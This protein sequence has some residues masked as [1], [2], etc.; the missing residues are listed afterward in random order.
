MIYPLFCH[1][2]IHA[3]DRLKKWGRFQ[4]GEPMLLWQLKIII[5][6]LGV[7]FSNMISFFWNQL[8]MPCVSSN[9]TG[10]FLH[11]SRFFNIS[12]SWSIMGMSWQ[13][14]RIQPCISVTHCNLPLMDGA[15]RNHLG[16][17]GRSRVSRGQGVRLG[18][19]RRFSWREKSISER[20]LKMTC[21]IT[22]F[23]EWYGYAWHAW[24]EIFVNRQLV[25]MIDTVNP[26]S[27]NPY[28]D[29]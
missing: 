24:H 7:D 4:F 13:A 9:F 23:V 21:K 16:I 22:I 28:S 15:P 12:Q 10:H 1:H 14:R 26:G 6:P 27:I 11:F 2:V 5:H 20:D 17:Q 3:F 25:G 19:L 8:I 18:I 29:N